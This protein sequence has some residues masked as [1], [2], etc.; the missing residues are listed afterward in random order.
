MSHEASRGRPRQGV[1][2]PSRERPHSPC[3]L[4]PVRPRPVAPPP[5]PT[6]PTARRVSLILQPLPQSPPDDGLTPQ[7]GR[8]DLRSH[9][10]PHSTVPI[11][12]GITGHCVLTLCPRSAPT[13]HCAPRSPPRKQHRTDYLARVIT[14]SKPARQIS[15]PLRAS[16]LYTKVSSISGFV[17]TE[18]PTAVQPQH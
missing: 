11:P 10:R 15:R 16:A 3:R 13:L 5:R 14:A 18:T 17:P 9:Q 2:S 1:R 8:R 7:N 12:A 4:R 6:F